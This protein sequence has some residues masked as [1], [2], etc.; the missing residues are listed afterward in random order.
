MVEDTLTRM[1]W[2][3]VEKSGSLP[4]Q[5]MKRGGRWQ[6]LAWS[7]VGDAVREAA[8]GLLALGQQRGDTVALLSASRAEWVQGDKAILSAGCVT[9]PIYATYTPELI[10]H[11]I[12]DAG[13]TTLIVEDPAQLEK[14]LEA[15]GKM[16]GL[17]RIVVIEGYEGQAPFVVTWDQLRRL[18]RDHADRLKSEL[19][20]RVASVRPDDVAT[21]VYTSGTTGPPKGVVQTH[22]NHTAALAAVAEVTQ[23]RAGEV[24]LLFLP[25]AHSFA[26]LEAFMGVYV[27]LTTAFAESLDT[28]AADLREVRPH[29]FCSVPRLFEKV[30][31]KILA[32]VEG[33]S[34][35]KKRIFFW[36]LGVGREVSRLR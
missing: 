6:T 34:P 19:A 25:L 32:G 15:K 17:E 11:I 18:G 26:R 14:V 24:H 36:A 21:I 31:T 33:G 35:L 7:E 10:A 1:F 28:V 4:A 2:S 22:A 5:M 9:V 13:A 27:G 20:E 3:R 23:L 29:F 8:L 12:N 16:A 30:Y